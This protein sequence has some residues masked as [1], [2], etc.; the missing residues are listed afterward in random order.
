MKVVPSSFQLTFGK[1][2]TGMIAE[3][4][5]APIGMLLVDFGRCENPGLVD[6]PAHPAVGHFP[7]GRCMSA[8]DPQ[9]RSREIEFLVF[10]RK[11]GIS[12]ETGICLDY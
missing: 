5:D 6:R 7:L 12:I 8:F 11:L 10:T 1:G 3:L 2:L 4:D 9:C